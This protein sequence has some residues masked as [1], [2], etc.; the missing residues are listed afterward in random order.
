MYLEALV[1]TKVVEFY[2]TRD[3][4]KEINCAINITFDLEI[5][6]SDV[7]YE[8]LDVS[9]R[10]EA[11][12]VSHVPRSGCFWTAVTLQRHVPF[13]GNNDRGYTTASSFSR[14][15]QIVFVGCIVKVTQGSLL[16]LHKREIL[17]AVRYIG[18][19]T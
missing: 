15:F 4:F 9:L 14:L 10:R 1:V 17:P 13:W 11:A 19:V 3:I 5:L 18:Q 2:C 12:D 6:L 7:E 8:V 16:A